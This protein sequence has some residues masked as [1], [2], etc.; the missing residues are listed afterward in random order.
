MARHQIALFSGIIFCYG[1]HAIIK[2]GESS[3]ASFLACIEESISEREGKQFASAPRSPASKPTLPEL[4]NLKTPTGSTVNI[5][6]QIGTFYSILGPLLL[7]DDNGV[8]ISAITNQHHHNAVAINQEILTQWL[9]GQGKQPVTWSTLLG[10][11]D[12]V[13]LS[14]L[15]K[16]VRKYLNVSETSPAQ[17]FGETVTDMHL[18]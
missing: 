15:T 14:V 9:Q 11:L 18:L 10:V 3:L 16:M 7:N 2:R 5:V 6:K 13:G 4:L 17:T 8:V 12:D 1:W